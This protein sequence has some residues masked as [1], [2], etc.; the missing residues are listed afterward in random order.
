MTGS[1]DGQSG[2]ASAGVDLTRDDPGLDLDA[3][4][5]CLN[6]EYGL[7]VS[8]IMFLPLGY[9]LNAAVYKVIGEDG[10]AYF[11]KV[12]F[13]P[14]REAGL[15]VPWA[16]ANRGIQNVL[17]PLQTRSSQL[18]CSCG[19]RSL[20]LY[21]FI[22]GENAMTAGMTDEQWRDFGST[23]QAAHFR[24]LAEGFRRR[25]PVET[26]ALLLRAPVRRF[27]SLSGTP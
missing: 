4:T 19:G 22:A 27:P 20:I 16:L 18:W 1:G 3:I 15:L 21:P 11:L 26:F 5:A 24:G 23:L 7:R 9:D 12:R 25:L 14:V 13:G 2:D 17:A 6:A 8:A 10:R